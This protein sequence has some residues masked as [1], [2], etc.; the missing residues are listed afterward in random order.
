M[1]IAEL[2]R[3]VSAWADLGT[4]QRPISIRVGSQYPEIDVTQQ[5]QPAFTRKAFDTDKEANSASAS[6]LG[7][8][9]EARMDKIRILLC[10]GKESDFKSKPLSKMA[11]ILWIA[12]ACCQFQR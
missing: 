5:L 10:T 9:L 4:C 12:S 7:L 2:R 3:S 8:Q 1:L 11:A 6:A